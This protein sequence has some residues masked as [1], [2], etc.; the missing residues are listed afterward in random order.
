M[1][2]IKECPREIIMTRSS[3]YV[4]LPVSSN[5]VMEDE[6][7]FPLPI[8][9]ALIENLPE[10]IN[11]EI[12]YSDALG[13]MRSYY[14]GME[15]YGECQNAIS[16]A[17]KAFIDSLNNNKPLLEV[18]S[19]YFGLS[20]DAVSKTMPPAVIGAGERDKF[21]LIREPWGEKL[22]KQITLVLGRDLVRREDGSFN[23]LVRKD[24]KALL[25]QAMDK[26]SRATGLMKA[27]R[28]P[29]KK[30]EAFEDAV[31]WELNNI[32][33]DIEKRE[34]RKRAAM[35]EIERL[36]EIGDPLN[37]LSNLGLYILGLAILTFSFGFFGHFGHRAANG[38]DRSLLGNRPRQ[39]EED[40]KGNPPADGDSGDGKAKKEPA[41][42]PPTTVSFSWDAARNA[43]RKGVPANALERAASSSAAKAL[44]FG[45]AALYVAQKMPS[46]LAQ[47]ALAIKTF[48]FTLASPAATAAEEEY[49]RFKNR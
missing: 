5:V 44:A 31:Y 33:S 21:S 4:R 30:I 3:G 14:I 7:T 22:A 25:Q 32:V 10:D 1:P 9:Q 19:K 41:A 34:D 12:C 15:K 8:S 27:K 23:Y 16:A 26:L 18:D 29:D 38:L 40:N 11:K 35:G 45:A 39:A 24:D 20:D 42:R 49:L 37:F 13:D 17:G 2:S 6:R 43:A 46:L 36:L 48:A 47:R 28:E